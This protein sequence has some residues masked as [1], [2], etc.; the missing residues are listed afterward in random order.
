MYGFVLRVKHAGALSLSQVPGTY[1]AIHGG[2]HR[3]DG[4]T[5]K[6]HVRDDAFV[7]GKG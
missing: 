5:N 3:I 2:G 4:G 7:A 6:K 1:G